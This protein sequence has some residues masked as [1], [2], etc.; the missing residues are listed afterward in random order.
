K[1]AG[2]LDS[3]PAVIDQLINKAGFRI[4]P[5]LLTQILNES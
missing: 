5:D 4:S 3:L 1:Q 2:E